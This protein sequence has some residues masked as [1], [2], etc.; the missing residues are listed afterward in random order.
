MNLRQL[1]W[2]FLCVHSAFAAISDREEWDKRFYNFTGPFIV[3]PGSGGAP[4][5]I[6]VYR[7]G[8]FLVGGKF[9]NLADNALLNLARWDGTT[10]QKPFAHV[11]SAAANA[12]EI[13]IAF[14]SEIDRINGI[15]AIA[16]RQADPQSA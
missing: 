5:P 8:E 13:Q 2:L 1:A 6:A 11:S 9:T 12:G 7:A 14:T 3:D 15:H 4:G 16:T 10:W